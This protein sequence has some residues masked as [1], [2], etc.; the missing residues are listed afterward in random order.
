[1]PVM[2]DRRSVA[3]N[4]VSGNVLA[5][6]QFEFLPYPARVEFGLTGSAI[7][8]NATVTTGNDVLQADQEVN[9]QNRLPLYPDDFILIDVVR[10]GER[11]VV[12]YRNTTVGAINAFTSVRITP[13]G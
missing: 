10:P 5:G 12:N 7:G 13:I 3:A 8:L 9:A 2:S 11:I 1:M 6:S 4:S